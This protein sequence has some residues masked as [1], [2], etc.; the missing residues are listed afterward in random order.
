FS[1]IRGYTTL[2]ERLGAQEVVAFLNEHFTAMTDEIVAHGGTIDKFMGD[3]VMAVF[4]DPGKPAPDD[5][6]RAVRAAIAMVQ[7]REALNRERS[8]RGLE[9]IEIG[10]GI[11]SGLIVMGNIGSSRRFTFTV[12]GDAV[13]SASRLEGLTK[14]MG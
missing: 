9:P 12:I 1:D 10:V 3:A 14:T 4:G 11:D 13:N 7:R 5:A 8:R 2:T 6:I